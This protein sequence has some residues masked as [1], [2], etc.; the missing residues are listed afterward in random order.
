VLSKGLAARRA[1]DR[2]E[3]TITALARRYRVGVPAMH[4][5]V[6]AALD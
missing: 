3:E 2:N 4:A 6:Q 5:I 1:W